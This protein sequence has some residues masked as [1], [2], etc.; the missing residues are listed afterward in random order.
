MLLLFKNGLPA[1]VKKE[2]GCRQSEYFHMRANRPEQIKKE[3]K[4]IL[5]ICS[6]HLIDLLDFYS[7]VHSTAVRFRKWNV[8]VNNEL[9]STSLN[10]KPKIA[11]YDM[12]WKLS[13][14]FIH[15]TNVFNKIQ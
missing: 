12:N 11:L 5:I 15:G 8:S 6:G 4:V 2:S 3:T 14:H 10:F 13:S 9:V 7:L 1:T